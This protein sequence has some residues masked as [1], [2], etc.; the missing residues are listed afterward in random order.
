MSTI[1]ECWVQRDTEKK[2]NTN[3]KTTF[4][5][6]PKSDK[7][8]DTNFDSPFL[9]SEAKKVKDVLDDLIKDYAVKD[10][11]NIVTKKITANPLNVCQ[12][13][14]GK[15]NTAFLYKVKKIKTRKCI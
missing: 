11:S 9:K 8:I 3:I 5:L 1:G 4:Q 14:S 10:E 7:C 13:Y 2:N 15:A 12:S 6:L